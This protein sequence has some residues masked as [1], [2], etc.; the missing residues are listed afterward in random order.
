MGWGGVGVG[1]GGGGRCVWEGAVVVRG[2][3][4]REVQE[5]ME[6]LLWLVRI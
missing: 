4:G 3:L 5:V 1:D 6:A 2:E